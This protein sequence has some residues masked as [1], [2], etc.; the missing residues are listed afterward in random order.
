MKAEDKAMASVIADNNKELSRLQNSIS[1]WDRAASADA[2]QWK[3][4]NSRLVEQRECLA[5][6]LKMLKRDTHLLLQTQS[7]RLKAMCI[8]RYEQI[9]ESRSLAGGKGECKDHNA[10]QN[11]QKYPC[12]SRL[13]LS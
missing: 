6:Q 11:L 7:E 5:N 1:Y 12:G 3:R 13:A 9:T 4:T 2:L 8:S 10:E